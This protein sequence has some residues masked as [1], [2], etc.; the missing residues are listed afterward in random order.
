MVKGVVAIVGRPNVG[1]ST[2]F[3]R[4]VGS[5]S[6]IVDDSPGVTRDRI[7]KEA[8]WSGS[9]FLLVDTGGILPGRAADINSSAQINDEV[10]K[11]VQLAIDESDVIIFVVDGK[12]GPTGVDEDVA[13]ILRRSKKPV[14]LAVNKIDTPKDELNVPE[15]Y[16]LGLGEPHSVSAMV[17]SGGVGDIL[18][19]VIDHLPKGKK[20]RV[21]DEEILED[22]DVDNMP[23]SL[24]LVGKP[25]VGKSSIL[26]I[27]C[28]EKRTIVTDEPGTTRDA[29]HTIIKH[30]GREITLIDTAGIRRR[31]KVEYGIEAFSVVRSFRAISEADVVVQIVD[32]SEPISDQDQKIAS[33]IEEAG[34]GVVIVMNKW[35]LFENKSSTKMN[36]LKRDI[37]NDLRAINYA[38]VLFTSA[39]EKVRVGKIIEAA[40]LAFAQNHRRV[41]TSLMNQCI[42][43]CIALVP[44]PAGKRG[45]RL[46]IYYATQVSVGPP[47]FALFVNDTKLMTDNYR[48]YLERKLRET[49]GFEGTPIRILT[50]PKKK[51]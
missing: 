49:F 45:K 34:R 27:L 14:L 1:K 50:R 32:S 33:K 21:S 44:P 42:S 4:C 16:S 9:K 18:D 35:D 12:Q 13:N 3:N 2:F 31:T 48:T 37:E 15:F 10:N 30:N 23:F 39:T 25:N 46:K 7:Y 47:T 43:E 38:P 28:G 24:A 19:L 22:E 20:G 36:E 26:N 8:E 51:Q 40:A 17:G 6:S 41:T 11:Q 29:I 5:R